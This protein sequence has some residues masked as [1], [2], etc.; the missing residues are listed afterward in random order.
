MT[1]FT[2]QVNYKKQFQGPTVYINRVEWRQGWSGCVS[3]DFRCPSCATLAS[4]RATNYC[5]YLLFIKLLFIA[6]NAETV[7]FYLKPNWL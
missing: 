2:S 3:N 6:L 7:S 5:S 1:I 4:L